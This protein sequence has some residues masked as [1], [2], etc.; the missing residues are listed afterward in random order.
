MKTLYVGI[1]DFPYLY[2]A[3]ELV[4][5]QFTPIHISSEDVEILYGSY[6]PDIDIHSLSQELLDSYDQLI[7]CSDGKF[8]IITLRKEI[9]FNEVSKTKN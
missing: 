1:Y 9:N 5:G 7:L 3:Q 8:S 6:I 4:N 2:T